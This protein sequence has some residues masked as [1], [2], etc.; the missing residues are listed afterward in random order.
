MRVLEAIFWFIWMLVI[1]FLVLTFPNYKTY[2][3]ILFV[4]FFLLVGIGM[5]H[6]IWNRRHLHRLKVMIKNINFEP[7]EEEIKKMEKI[8]EECNSKVLNL[9]SQLN[10]FEN[11]KLE[12]EKKYREVVR[13]VLDVDNELNRKYKILGESIIKLSKDTKK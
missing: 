10:D 6:Q 5:F 2:E 1:I 7:L 13:K 8:Q 4:L 9:E 3:L 12:Q 11:Y